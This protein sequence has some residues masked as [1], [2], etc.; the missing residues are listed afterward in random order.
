MSRQK[1]H[2]MLGWRRKKILEKIKLE[3]NEKKKKR[4][5]KKNKRNSKRRKKLSWYIYTLFCSR[6]KFEK[7]KKKCLRQQ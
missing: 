7:V 5:G 2:T 1:L 4:N 6:A 3:P